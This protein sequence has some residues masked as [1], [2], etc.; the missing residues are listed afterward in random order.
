MKH[1]KKLIFCNP[2]IVYGGWIPNTEMGQAAVKSYQTLKNWRQH[3]QL[4]GFIGA[5]VS[6]YNGGV[7]NKFYILSPVSTPAD[8]SQTTRKLGIALK[9][10]NFDFWTD[11]GGGASYN[12]NVDWNGSQLNN[13]VVWIRSFYDYSTGTP[14]DYTTEPA[15][16]SY[17]WFADSTQSL[18]DAQYS[19]G[20]R[21]D[22]LEAPEISVAAMAVFS[23]P[24]WTLTLAASQGLV[25]GNFAA[26][27]TLRGYDSGGDSGTSIG[28]ITHNMDNS[29]DGILQNTKRAILSY[30]HPGGCLVVDSGVGAVYNGLQEYGTGAPGTAVLPI[31]VRGRNLR[32]RTSF[33]N[34][35][36][37]VVMMA[38][39][40][41]GTKLRI[42][43][44]QTTDTI[45]YNFVG[46]QTGTPAMVVI[47]DAF[48]YDPRGDDLTIEFEVSNTKAVI[49]HSLSIFE[50][51]GAEV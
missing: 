34:D 40:D 3:D 28:A 8:T 36:C 20:Y 10:W 14:Q 42:T 47:Q 25:S 48:R 18:I 35:N 39:W 37:D 16:D 43:S 26:T 46:S 5:P 4:C 13:Y 50:T 33:P 45:V 22:L 24:E 12:Q 49:I 21:Y 1:K 6:D 7:S 44:A 23:L 32:G 11:P 41:T 19:N 51:T 17:L 27:H 30:M 9:R 29:T 38:Q 15:G 31:K 2:D